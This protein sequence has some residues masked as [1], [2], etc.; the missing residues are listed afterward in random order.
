MDFNRFKILKNLYTVYSISDLCKKHL[1]SYS[2]RLETVLVFFI[3]NACYIWITFYMC[4]YN[5]G[6]FLLMTVLYNVSAV[7][8]WCKLPAAIKKCFRLLLMIK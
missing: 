4:I 3:Q 2:N 1:K 5:L 6:K 8:L 7:E